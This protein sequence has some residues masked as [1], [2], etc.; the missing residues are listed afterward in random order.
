MH[1]SAGAAGNRPNPLLFKKLHPMTQTTK[2]EQVTL[3]PCPSGHNSI[4]I[5]YDDEAEQH[6]VACSGHPSCRWAMY[7]ATEP[8]AITAWNARLTSQPAPSD[9]VEAAR[10]RLLAL[11]ECRDL[12]TVY[13]S[14]WCA[15]RAAQFSADIRAALSHQAS[16][17]PQHPAP[18]GEGLADDVR[19][20]VIAARCVMDENASA[21]SRIELDRAAEAFASRVPWENEDEA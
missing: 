16:D 9:L 10:E 5:G 12:G 3:L 11:A 19:R 18:V 2:N 6:F 4:E 14:E 7:G 17:T 8:E 13:G 1:A 20:L 21:E 15:D